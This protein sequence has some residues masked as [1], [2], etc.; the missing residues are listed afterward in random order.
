MDAGN[1]ALIAYISFGIFVILIIATIL[2]LA[3]NIF[4][5]CKRSTRTETY[6]TELTEFD[7]SLQ[8][9]TEVSPEI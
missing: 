7:N 9:T 5:H 3:S 6:T 4:L 1:L 8:K 2:T